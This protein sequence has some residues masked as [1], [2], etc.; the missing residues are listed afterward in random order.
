VDEL[1][2]FA[3]PYLKYKTSDKP[4]TGYRTGLK[5]NAHGRERRKNTST[6]IFPKL[7]FVY[8]LKIQK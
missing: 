4:K 7:I 1:I 2:L 6:L 8:P 3:T 5:I